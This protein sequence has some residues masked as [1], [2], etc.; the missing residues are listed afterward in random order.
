MK[1]KKRVP[2][3]N[4]HSCSVVYDLDQSI[5]GEKI[6]NNALTVEDSPIKIIR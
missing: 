4:C 1:N 5:V 6:S 2:I 3:E